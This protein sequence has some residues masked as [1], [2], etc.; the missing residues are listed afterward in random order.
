MKIICYNNNLHLIPPALPPR[1]IDF[2]ELTIVAKG[3]LV[4]LIDG[5]EYRVRE[6]EGVFLSVN[7]LRERPDG[8]SPCTYYSFN[9]L[10]AEKAGLPTFIPHALNGERKLLLAAADEIK[11]NFY[12][13]GNEQLGLLLDCFL[14]NLK[15]DLKRAEEH[16]L[17]V[18]IKQFVNEHLSEKITLTR[19]G[20][21]LFFSPLYCETLFTKHT[22]YSIIRYVMKRRIDEAKN[23]LLDGTLSLKKIAETVGF[24]DY[25][26]FSRVFKNLTGNTPSQY[27]RSVS[28]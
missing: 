1:K 4:Y 17:I 21:A 27:K 11:R 9:F 7:S 14:E 25:N 24:E 22:G 13:N 3:E 23:L 5:V 28:L 20:E 19:I 6:G 10:S 18:K 12:P 2:N 26:Y 15:A 8:L 16:P